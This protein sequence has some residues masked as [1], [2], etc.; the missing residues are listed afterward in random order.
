MCKARCVNAT[1]KIAIKS[2]RGVAEKQVRYIGRHS[3]A[4]ELSLDMISRCSP[5][6]DEVLIS[7]VE[8][9]C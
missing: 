7:Y 1:N 9:S 2:R 8:L 4:P 5:L 6:T 3:V